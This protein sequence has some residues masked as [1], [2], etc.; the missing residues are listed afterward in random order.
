MSQCLHPIFIKVDRRNQSRKH[1]ALV[2]S[3]V[4]EARTRYKDIRPTLIDVVPVP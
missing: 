4:Y 3:P 2:S 1:I